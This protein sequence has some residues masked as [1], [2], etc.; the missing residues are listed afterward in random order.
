ML[1]WP[2]VGFMAV[3]HATLTTLTLRVFPPSGSVSVTLPTS[4]EVPSVWGMRPNQRVAA[5][6]NGVAFG[7]N[8]PDEV[9]FAH[10]REFVPR[11]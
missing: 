10:A 2:A 6:A 9:S 3:G 7:L 1:D 8:P 5:S 4:I 11:V